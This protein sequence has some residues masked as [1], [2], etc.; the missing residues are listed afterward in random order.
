LFGF[1]L[2]VRLLAP[3]SLGKYFQPLAVVAD[4]GASLRFGLFSC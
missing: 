4:R 1:I 3:L 2:S